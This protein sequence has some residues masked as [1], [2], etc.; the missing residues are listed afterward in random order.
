MRR[1]VK[2]LII[3][4]AVV[5]VLLI[6]GFFFVRSFLTPARMQS[7]AQKMASETFQRPVEIGRV[8]LHLGFQIGIGIEKI[9]VPNVQGF[10]PEAMLEIEK[11]VLKLQLLPLFTRRVV[12][13]SV[14]LVKPDINIEQNKKGELNFAGLALADMKGAGWQVSLSSIRIIDGELHYYSALNKADYSVSNIDQSVKFRGSRISASGNLS[15]EIAE[16]K[17]VPELKLE[18]SN[19][20]QYDTLSKDIDLRKISITARG[21]Q[22][23]VSGAIE[24]SSSL[25]LDGSVEV[26]DLSSLLSL[27]PADSRPEALEGSIKGNIA[28]SGTVEKPTIGGLVEIN[29]VKVVPRNMERGLE[30]ING[31]I[32]FDHT[33]VENI[34]IHANMGS[35]SISVSGSVAEINTKIPKLNITAGLEGNLK[36]F[37]NISKEMKNIVLSGPISLKINLKGTV[38]NPQYSGDIKTSDALID[39][40]GFGEPLR[41]LYFTGQLQENGLKISSCKGM[42]GQSDFSLT[43]QITNFKEPVIYINNR[44]KYID[45]DEL[46]PQPQAGKEKKEGAMPL[47][48]RGS[49]NISRLV[50]MDMEFKNVNADF[51]YNKGIIDLKD[52]RAQSFDGEVF[53]DFYYNANRPEPYRISSRMQSVSSQKILQRFLKFNRLQGTVDGKVDFNGRGLDKKAVTSNMNGTGN[54]KFREGKFSNFPVLTKM[55]DWLGLKSYENVEFSNLQCAFTIENGQAELKDWTLSAR[56]GDFLTSG[57]VGLD[58]RLN[59][60]VAVT[61]SKSNSGIVKRYHGDWLFYVN[62]QGQAVIDLIVTGKTNSPSFKLDRNKIKQR[63]GGKIKDQFEQKKKDFEQKIKEWLKWP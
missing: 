49:L 59:L 18:I 14:E 32:S 57:T 31:S 29:N 1:F 50:G 38:R 24:K 63:L 6:A 19:D 53:L 28:L 48:I 23:K 43:G 27:I 4:V 5:V 58:G 56:A 44:S 22:L 54:L 52:C 60:Q 36:D 3:A 26:R 25:D 13:N 15:A 12:I 62:D 61:L 20:L 11:S 40:I 46:L 35:T 17:N 7:I 33:S 21:V 55:L 41:N 10:S 37:Q 9:S 47:E 39:G 30:K 16:A 45:L 34:D 8:S 51:S 2:V 42:V